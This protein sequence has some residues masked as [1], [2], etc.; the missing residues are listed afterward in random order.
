MGSWA[1]NSQLK[2]MNYAIVEGTSGQWAINNSVKNII[3][4]YVKNIMD[5]NNSRAHFNSYFNRRGRNYIAVNEK[6]QILGFAILGPNRHTGTTRL[7]VI[8]TKPGRGVG[9]VLLSQIE[10]NARGRGVRK[11]R[12]MDPVNNAL[13]FYRHMGY[14]PAKKVNGNNTMT[15]K[16]NKRKSPSRPSPKRPSSSPTSSARQ[17][18]TRQTPRP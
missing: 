3:F 2:L 11:I 16:L 12:I 9:G 6:G 10:N 14:K 7:Y 1:L 15:K 8:G 17:S 4:Q 18:A 13:S 5:P